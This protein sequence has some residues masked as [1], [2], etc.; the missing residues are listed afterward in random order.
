MYLL[1]IYKILSVYVYIYIGQARLPYFA[2]ELSCGGGTYVRSLMADIAENLNTAAHMVM[3]K[4]KR[5]KWKKKKKK[6]KI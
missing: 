1:C 4:K 6:K 5:T 3:I 2:L